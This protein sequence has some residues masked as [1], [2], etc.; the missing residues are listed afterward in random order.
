[1][2]DEYTDAT[3]EAADSAS[4]PS[5]SAADGQSSLPSL[6]QSVRSKELRTARNVLVIVGVLTV[7][8]NL[9]FFTQAEQ[10][11]DSQI[12][13]LQINGQLQ[14][15]SPSQ[16]AELRSQAIRMVKL[17]HGGT[18]ALGAV[19][20]VLGLAVKSFPVPATVLGLILYL[21]GIAVFAAINPASLVQGIIFKIIIVVCLFQSVKSALAHQRQE[22]ASLMMDPPPEFG[23]TT[24][25]GQL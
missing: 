19:F 3:N 22:R 18:V 12:R 5:L 16:V 23:T 2:N 24:Q 21:A 14:N 4:L 25:D 7:A 17:I 1:M 9:F 15:A 8:V 20:I 11:V 10:A 6:S 13:D